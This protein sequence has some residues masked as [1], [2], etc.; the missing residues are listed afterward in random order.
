[1]YALCED[2]AAPG[3]RGSHMSTPPIA[4]AHK[5]RVRSNAAVPRVKEAAERELEL[6]DLRD[7]LRALK[8]G[9]FTARVAP[10]ER[11]MS[12]EVATA[13]NDLATLLDGTSGE[14]ARVS[15]VVGRDGVMLERVEI[16]G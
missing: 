10:G 12:K 5:P 8:A 3:P 2:P 4:T 7:A 9:D 13:F 16:E 1:M 14:F 6:G 11:R 15:K